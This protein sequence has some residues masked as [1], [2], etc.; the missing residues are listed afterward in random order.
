MIMCESVSRRYSAYFTGVSL[1]ILD[2]I[3]FLYM[4]F[5]IWILGDMP[6]CTSENGDDV[7]RKDANKFVSPMVR[8]F[9][10]LDPS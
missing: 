3:C 5:C 9:R 6:T 8:P 1:K 7:G 10:H 4:A 2:A